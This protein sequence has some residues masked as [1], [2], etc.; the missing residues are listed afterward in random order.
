MVLFPVAFA[1][2]AAGF[3][4][5]LM[6]LWNW[7]MPTIFGVAAINFWQALGLLMLSR[8]LFGGMGRMGHKHGHRHH[9]NMMR[10]KWMK[11]TPEQRAEFV[12]KRHAAMHCCH[13]GFGGK[14][15]EQDSPE[16]ND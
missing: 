4:A 13:P 9:G 7:L 8:L 10:E 15:V 14:G 2:C 6:L 1:G 12:K 3:S 16:N 11:M 5:A